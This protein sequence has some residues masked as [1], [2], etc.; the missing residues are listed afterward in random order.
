MAGRDITLELRT[1]EVTQASSRVA[2]S[3]PVRRWVGEVLRHLAR[4]GGVVAEGRDL[5]TAVFPEAEV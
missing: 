2:T 4:D 3:P 5:G 1:P